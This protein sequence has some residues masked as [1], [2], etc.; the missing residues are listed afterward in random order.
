MIC[1]SSSSLLKGKVIFPFPL[2]SHANFTGTP[3]AAVRCFAIT[4]K[5]CAGDALRLAVAVG[6]RLLIFLSPL[7]DLT[8]TESLA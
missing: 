8:D 3:K 4:S 2:R 7:L 1:S 5:F 6:G